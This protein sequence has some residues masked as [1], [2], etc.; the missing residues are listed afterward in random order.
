MRPSYLSC[1]KIKCWGGSGERGWGR[2]RLTRYY[3]KNYFIFERIV[4]RDKSGS[5][6]NLRTD[7]PHITPFLQKIL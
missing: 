5:F 7:S 4:K 2:G 3:G 1:F 6:L